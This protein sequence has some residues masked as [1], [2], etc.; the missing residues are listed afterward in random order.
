MIDER[1]QISLIKLYF[2]FTHILFLSLSSW[3]VI[4]EQTIT[5]T[6]INPPIK[7]NK[8][9]SKFLSKGQMRK[10]QFLYENDYFIWNEAE[11][12]LRVC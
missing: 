12:Y 4:M 8:H 3:L 6:S 1:N 2:L 9:D 11:M 10:A 5:Q 7:I